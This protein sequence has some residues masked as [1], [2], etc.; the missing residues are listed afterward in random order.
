MTMSSIP[1]PPGP[2]GSAASAPRRRLPDRPLSRRA[3]GL[4]ALAVPGLLGLAGCGSDSGSDDPRALRIVDYYNTPADDVAINGTFTKCAEELGLTFSRERVPG[5]Q[6]IAKVLQMGSS[7]TLPDL[8]MLDNPN[9]QQVAA[10]GALAPLEQYGITT[11]GLTAPVADLGRYDGTLYGIAPTVNT[12]ALFYDAAALEQAGLA[13]PTT[14]DELRE[15]AEALTTKDR[16]GLAFSAIASYEGTFQFMP[17]MWS[18]GGDETDLDGEGVIGASRFWSDLVRDGLVSRSVVNWG[19]GDVIDQFKA[20]NVAMVVNGPWNIAGLDADTPDLDWDVVTIPVPEAGTDP[21]A[22]LGGEVWTVP[23]TGDEEKQA[24]AAELLKAFV[25]PENQ[26]YMAGERSTIPGDAE[27]AQEFAREHPELG[28]FVEQVSTA[29]SRTAQ[30]GP[31]WPRT[32]KAIYTANQ[33]VL[34]D[35]TDPAEAFDEA[36][37][38]VS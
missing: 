27:A 10:S 12:I 16:Y 1:G 14:W 13:P 36:A 2:P 19:Q 18:H 5:D 9:V 21:I 25:A 17:F 30:L 26:L 33:R 22:P 6:L 34:V 11:D 7:R 29:R 38:T 35:D 24:K 37:R 23:V 28:T 15:A 20:G 32:A 8:L 31:D 4:G 3:L